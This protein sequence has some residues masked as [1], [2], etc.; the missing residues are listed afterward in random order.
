M[1]N[2]D[3][4]DDDN[5]NDEDVGDAGDRLKTTEISH[6]YRACYWDAILVRI[7]VVQLSRVSSCTGNNILSVGHKVWLL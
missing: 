2:I 6:I 5:D 1:N 3:S 4:T 7:L